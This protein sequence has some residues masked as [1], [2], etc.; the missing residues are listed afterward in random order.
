MSKVLYPVHY[1]NAPEL[2]TMKF[3]FQVGATGGAEPDAIVPASCGVSDVIRNATAGQY[4]ITFEEKFPVF[5]GLVGTV[6]E[7]EETHDLIVK[8][9]VGDYVASTG[10]LTVQVVGA[11]G[12]TADEDV[13]ENDWVY[14]EVTFCR[15]STL[16]PSGSI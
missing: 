7:A 9:G 4:E 8:A 13:V 12:S 11:D 16:A 14:L 3:R 15:K 10:V 1:V 2:V 5:I 6:L